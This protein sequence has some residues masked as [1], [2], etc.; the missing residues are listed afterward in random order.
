MAKPRRSAMLC[1]IVKKHRGATMDTECFLKYFSQHPRVE[2]I[3]NAG[4]ALSLVARRGL[5][6][7]VA[8]VDPSS[9]V[10]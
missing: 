7:K 6:V 1:Y 3:G 9:D 4:H 5:P 10:R 2:C 8:A